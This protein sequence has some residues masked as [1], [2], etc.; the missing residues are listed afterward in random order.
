MFMQGKLLQLINQARFVIVQVMS[1]RSLG[2][3]VFDCPNHGGTL[4]RRLLGAKPQFAL[5]AWRNW[6]EELGSQF[7]RDEKIRRIQGV[8]EETR[9]LWIGE[10][11]LLRE[12]LKPQC[13]L[14]WF[15]KR[16]LDYTEYYSDP[17]LVFGEFP[18]LIDGR[19]IRSVRPL[20][21]GFIECVTS[22]GSPQPLFNRF[23]GEPH[24]LNP[25]F[26]MPYHNVYY[27]SPEMHEGA[28]VELRQMVSDLAS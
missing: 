17:E 27:P 24:C 25:A 3:S 16:E 26:K 10:M 7:E 6:M 5:E 2:N 11:C 9:T 20:F 4:V 14:F 28:A 12:A 23:S 15:S 18:H 13:V 19:C 8:M 22:R 1:G 21:D